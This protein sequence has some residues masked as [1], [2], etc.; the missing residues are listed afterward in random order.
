MVLDMYT[1]YVLESTKTGQY[2]VGYTGDL[3]QR[4]KA[5]NAGKNISTRFG[6]PWKIKYCRDFLKEKEAIRFER[7]LKSLKKRARIEQEFNRPGAIV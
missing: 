1:V 5:H 3:E 7:Y 6:R 2:Y 4:L